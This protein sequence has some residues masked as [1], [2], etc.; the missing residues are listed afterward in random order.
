MSTHVI[1]IRHGQTDWNV[2]PRF[3]GTADIPLNEAGVAQA[4]ALA[5]RLAS[6]PI[7]AVYSSP[8]RRATQTAEII[9][10]PHGLPV[11][12]VQGFASA[13]YGQWEGMLVAEVAR[14]HPDLYDLWLHHPEQLQFP[15]GE[16]LDQVR[17][18]AFRALME[19]L[20]RHPDQRI[21]VVSHQVVTRTLLCAVLGLSTAHYWRLGQATACLN[22]FTYKK[23]EFRLVTLNDTCH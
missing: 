14:Q 13:D 5:R 11:E 21:V 23:G 2:E 1:L 17:D 16:N 15:G 7:A 6:E 4:E 20:P 3:R 18:R 19:I 12:A 10:Q 9:A 8:L 22:R